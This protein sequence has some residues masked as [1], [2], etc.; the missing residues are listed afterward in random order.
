MQLAK[1]QGVC[2]AGINNG[3]PVV[4]PDVEQ[5]PG[6]IACDSRSKSEIVI[7]VRDPTG[8]IIG[9]L[10]ID[11]KVYNSFDKTDSDELLKIIDLIFI[12]D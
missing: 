12:Y 10:D 4:V 3:E 6:H 8:K 2:W 11:S 1:N 9:V 5:F 7:P